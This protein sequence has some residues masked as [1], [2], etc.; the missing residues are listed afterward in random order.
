MPTKERRTKKAKAAK[1]P[2]SSSGKKKEAP[3]QASKNPSPPNGSSPPSLSDP[4]DELEDYSKKFKASGHVA[5]DPLAIHNICNM[6]REF[7]VPKRFPQYFPIMSV[8]GSPGYVANN[9]CQGPTLKGINF[10][11]D[12]PRPLHSI[13]L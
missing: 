11:A 10:P 12:G 1:E 7:K 4:Q 8:K 2:T 13:L 3:K 6:D 9:Y 5:W